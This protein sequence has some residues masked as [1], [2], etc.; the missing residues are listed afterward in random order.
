[1]LFARIFVAK[2]ETTSG[3]TI[4]ET[5]EPPQSVE[6][7]RICFTVWLLIPSARYLLASAEVSRYRGMSSFPSQRVN[8]SLQP[9][10]RRVQQARNA[11]TGHG[12]E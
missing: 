6:R 10:E 4:A 7:L 11:R 1:M 2:A 9:P 12:C 8:G 5:I 3:F